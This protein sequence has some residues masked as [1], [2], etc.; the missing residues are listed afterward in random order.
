MNAPS[1]CFNQ[2]FL[3]TRSNISEPLDFLPSLKWQL[4]TLECLGQALYRLSC[5]GDDKKSPL[6]FDLV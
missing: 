1:G 6:N 4:H 5:T 3:Q 2:Y